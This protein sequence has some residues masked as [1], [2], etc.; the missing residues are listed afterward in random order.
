MRIFIS[1]AVS[2][3]FHQFGRSISYRQRNR[4]IAGSSDKFKSSIN[5]KIRR[6]A[7]RTRSQIYSGLSKGNTS[8]RPSYLSHCIKSG[9]GQQKSIGICQTDIF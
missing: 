2:Q 4:L 8:F 9:I 5:S 3:I 1:V 7:F 6:I